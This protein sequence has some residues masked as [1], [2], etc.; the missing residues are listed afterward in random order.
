[1]GIGSFPMFVKEQ[2]PQAEATM[3]IAIP[4]ANG[5]FSEHFGGAREFLVFQLDRQADACG[6][7][8]LLSAPEHKPGALPEWLAAQRMDAVIV[9][10]IGERAL[11]LLDQSGIDTFLAEGESEPVALAIACL[12]GKLPC[13]NKEN[14]R[15]DGSH[16][17]HDGH[18]C[19]HH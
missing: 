18:A 7:G 19:D 14:S 2:S 17:N 5:K 12:R 11:Q 13:A 4:M 16:H 1:M 6:A 9:S 15:C 8:E 3:K 10:A